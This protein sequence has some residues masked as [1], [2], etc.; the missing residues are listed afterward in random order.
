DE[1]LAGMPIPKPMRWG[2]HAYGFARPLHWLVALLGDDVA[3]VEAL[4]IRAGRET[5]GHRFHHPEPVAIAQPQDY[6]EALRGAKVLVDADE[7]R[8]R[9]VDEVERASKAAGGTARIDDGN[10]AQVNCLNEW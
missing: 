4:G 5:R 6:V 2:D 3:N 1:A 10:L 8:A 9:I 7:R